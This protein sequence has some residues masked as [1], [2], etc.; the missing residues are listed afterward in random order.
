MLESRESVT[1]LSTTQVDPAYFITAEVV[2]TSR[3]NFTSMLSF[4]QIRVDS[5]DNPME[6]HPIPMRC[7]DFILSTDVYNYL[8]PI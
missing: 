6:K 5:M 1:K 2:V 3:Y 7:G 8:D 4:F